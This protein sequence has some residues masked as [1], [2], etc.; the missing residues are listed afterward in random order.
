MASQP[1]QKKQLV[2]SHDLI[3]E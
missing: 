2:W 3:I 1:E